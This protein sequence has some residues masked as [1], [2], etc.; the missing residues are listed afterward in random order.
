MTD[1]AKELDQMLDEAIRV[2]STQ[3]EPVR[4]C[5]PEESVA[6]IQATRATF[7]KG[8][9]K[10]WWWEAF[11][12]APRRIG[13]EQGTPYFHE[14]VA[15]ETACWLILDDNRGDDDDLRVL[16]TTARGAECVL[17]ELYALEFYLVDK[18]YEWLLAENHHG[19][20]WLL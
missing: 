8:A 18:R 13:R 2:A 7:V 3:G 19:V 1:H 16:D 6:V 20:I 14:Y 12:V 15:L 5:G 11:S 17:S 9:R 4:R 10:H